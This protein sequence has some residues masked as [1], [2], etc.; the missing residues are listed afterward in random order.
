MGRKIMGFKALWLVAAFAVSLT[1]AGCS[2]DSPLSPGVDD[3]TGLNKTIV[4]AVVEVSLPI[5]ADSGG[6]IPIQSNGYNHAFVVEADGLDEDKVISV[7]AGKAK[8]NGK[9]MVEFDF[10]PDGLVFKKASKLQFDIGELN[11]NAV[12]AKLY[13]Y[14]PQ[15]SAWVLQA[16][17]KVKKGVA[18][19]NINHFSRYAISD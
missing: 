5:Q 2:G 6:L 4:S 8:I 7:K 12:S 13:Y 9:D 15:A 3:S 14:D 1:L 17:S 18:E 16:E 19:F 11:P 10:G